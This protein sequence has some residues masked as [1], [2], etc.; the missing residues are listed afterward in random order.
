MFLVFFFFIVA[1]RQPSLT[2][3]CYWTKATKIHKKKKVRARYSDEATQPN[4]RS[5]FLFVWNIK[6]NFTKENQYNRYYK[7]VV[8]YEWKLFIKK[9]IELVCA[10]YVYFGAYCWHRSNA[11]NMNRAPCGF[12]FLY[13]NLKIEF[14]KGCRRRYITFDIIIDFVCACCS[15][16]A[17]W[18]CPLNELIKSKY[19]HRFKSLIDFGFHFF[20]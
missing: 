8:K 5:W 6:R 18:Q 19:S 9:G 2:F 4:S 20:Y 12:S 3:V 10:W 14:G 13:F 16:F 11:Q 1:R 17:H 7:S 15:I